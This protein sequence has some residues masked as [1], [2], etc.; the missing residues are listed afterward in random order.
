MSAIVKM[1][2]RSIARVNEANQMSIAS[3]PLI[4]CPQPPPLPD[5]TPD[6]ER[7]IERQLGRTGLQVRLID[8]ASSAALWSIGVLALFLVAALFDHFIGLGT[9]GRALALLVLVGGSVYYLVTS[10]V[11]LLV[12]AINPAYAARTI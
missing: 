11:P 1:H 12:R 10:V 9:L 5:T 4:A 7:V 6:H 2:T 3:H 8:L